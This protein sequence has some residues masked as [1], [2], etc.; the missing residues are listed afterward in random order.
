MDKLYKIAHAEY[1]KHV[2][3]VPGTK[4]NKIILDYF[5]AVGHSWVQSDEVAWCAA[6]V[7]ACLEKA[8][9]KST[10]QLTAKSY[11]KW[12]KPTTTPKRGDIVVL[13]RGD[14]NGPY[15]HVGI[16]HGFSLANPNLVILLGGNQSNRVK[17]SPYDKS[18]IL[19]YRTM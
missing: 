13:S 10:K 4:S 16:F 8:G 5:K 15:G 3:E 19:G 9:M 18:R 2:K 1:M 6:F 17:M 14:V 11:L 12:G 7:G